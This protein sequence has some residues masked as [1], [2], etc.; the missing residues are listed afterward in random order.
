MGFRNFISTVIS[1]QINLSSILSAEAVKSSQ[2]AFWLTQIPLSQILNQPVNRI[3]DQIVDLQKAIGCEVGSAA[4]MEV[5]IAAK[6]NAVTGNKADIC[7]KPGNNCCCCPRTTEV[8]CSPTGNLI[9]NGDFEPD[10]TGWA[11]VNAVTDT[12]PEFSGMYVAR[13]NSL[14]TGS[15]SQ[16]IIIPEGCPL[17]LSF[18]ATAQNTVPTLTVNLRFRQGGAPIL[19]VV[20]KTIMFDNPFSFYTYVYLITPPAN[21]DNVTLEFTRNAVA[22]HIYIDNVTL[23]VP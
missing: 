4:D 17:Q 10:L 16:N 7:W 1:Q 20:T 5:A 23:E 11:A 6:I 8:T 18:A 14:T 19:P 9:T 12:T 13:L 15:I 22:G 3:I 21:A 2:T